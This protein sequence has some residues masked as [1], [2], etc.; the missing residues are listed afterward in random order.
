MAELTRKSYATCVYCDKAL[1]RS[2]KEAKRRARVMHPNKPLNAY[3]CPLSNG[4]HYGSLPDGGR[5]QARSILNHR[6]E[7]LWMNAS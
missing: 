2:R 1:Y 4:W 7:K 6:A 3:Y 5:D